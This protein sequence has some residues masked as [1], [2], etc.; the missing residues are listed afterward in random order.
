[1]SLEYRSPTDDELAAVL[2]A[3]HTAFGEEMK[4]D[5]LER[6]RKLLELDRVLAA[7][8]GE[9]PV[10]VTASWPFELT[11]PGGH[12]RGRGRDPRR[13]AAEP[14][15]ARD[16]ARADE[17][18][19]GRRPR[20]RRAARDP[21]G[22]GVADLRSLRVR[23]R[24]SVHA[25]WRPSDPRS[26]CATIPARA[27]RFASSSWTRRRSSSRRSTTGSASSA[28]DCSAAPT[29]GGVS[30]GSATPSTG[31]TAQAR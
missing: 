4:D 28:P 30:T 11:I 20:A 16:P 14:P 27:A 31:A 24:C 29:T 18:P 17:A 8:D 5:D 12:A 2:R 19:A 7:W 9:R 26:R 23:P 25:R 6:I 13:R 3:T 15:A 22:L 10:G 21:L 1:M